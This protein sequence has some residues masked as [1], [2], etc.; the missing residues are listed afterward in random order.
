MSRWKK[1]S[2]TNIVVWF[3]DLGLLSFLIFDFGFENFKDFRQYKLIVLPL[4]LL[5]LIA[6]NFYKFYKYRKDVDVNRSS[7]I[8]LFILLILIVLE[9]IM[10]L[11]NYETSVVETFFNARYVIEYGLLFYFFIRLTFLLRKVYSLY[12]NPAILFVGSFAIIALAGTFLLL[13]PSATTHEISFTDALFTATSATAVTGLIVL[14]TAKDFTPFGQTVIMILFQIGG[15]GMLTFT[16][17]FAY[18]FKS[19]ASFKESLYMRDI[20]GH[21]KLN[22]VMKTVMQI[23]AFSLILEGIGALFIYHSLAH[24]D[25]FKDRGFFA[26]FHAI[27]AYCNAGFSLASEG[28]FDSGLRF[29]YY[30][31]WVVMGL[32]VFGGLGY[33]I[34]YNVIQYLRKFVT[35]IFQKKERV[36]I[37]RVINL[38]T[39]IVLY[40]TAILIAAGAVFFLFSEQNTNLVP[41]TTAFGKFTTAMFSSITSR[42]AGF[43]TVDMTNFTIPGLLFMIFLM[44]V[45]ASPASTGGGIKTTTFAL[46][47]LNVFAIARDKKYIEIGTRRI[48]IEA[49]HR[50]FAIISISLAS[51][52]MGILLLLI[53]NPEFSLI[54]IAFEVFSAFSTV[55][56]SMGI[57]SQLSEYSK[58]VVILLMFFGRIGLLNLMIGLLK[59][60]GK[61]DYTYPEENI[62]IN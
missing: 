23:V 36:F 29:N 5:A 16:S 4:L 12:F 3:L 47:T 32:I 30:M 42:T 25:S 11:A 24:I 48:A 2:L 60:V 51:I 53:F 13:L 28:L 22:S 52:G 38:N 46:A 62:L 15:L 49:V 6:F 14:D 34:A 41:H 55:G 57:T 56:I 50:A 61:T 39:K 59:S 58:Y 26:V 8:S 19:G 7:R 18:F 31:Q 43:N 27:S 17:F 9:V 44:W 37:S 10:I 21:D 33:H 20:L 1:T 45:G 35:N 54:Q 40:T